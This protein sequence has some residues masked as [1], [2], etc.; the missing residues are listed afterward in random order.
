MASVIP[1][2]AKK[3]V[4]DAWAA[5]SLYV[6]LF[7]S[8][9][10]CASQS[11]YSACTNECAGT[12]YTTG[13]QVLTTTSAYSSS[14]AVL[15]AA[16]SAWTAASFTGARYAVVYVKSGATADKIRA[17]FDFGS[18]ASVTSGTMTIMWNASGL[19]KVSSI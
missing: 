19:I 2:N 6:A 7:L 16:D 9:S 18:D 4:T 10:N 12:G 5:E 13:G 14:D 11:I 17:I 1:A 15:D 3:E 8:T